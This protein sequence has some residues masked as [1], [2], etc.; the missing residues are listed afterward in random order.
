MRKL[1]SIA[2]TALVLTVGAFFVACGGD[3]PSAPAATLTVADISV[4]VGESSRIRPVFSDGRTA[5]VEYTFEGNDISI[6]NGEVEGLVADTV[7]EVTATAGELSAKFKVYVVTRPATDRGTLSFENVV[8]TTAQTITLAPVFSKEEGRSELTYSAVPAGILDFS[9]DGKM[10]VVDPSAIKTDT[11]VTVFAEGEYLSATFTVTVKAGDY[12]T[13]TIA[14][15]TVDAIGRV[16]IVPVFSKESGRSELTYECTP[17]GFLLFSEDG[18]ITVADPTAATDDMDVTVHA[19]GAYLET[20]FVVRVN[21]FDPGTLTLSLP[22]ERFE[23]R[24]NTLYANYSPR[25]LSLAFSSGWKT[26]EQFTYTVQEEFA[27]KVTVDAEGN[28]KAVGDFSVQ[29]TVRVTATSKS[30]TA[31]ADITVKYF[32]GASYNGYSLNLETQINNKL[33]DWR[34]RG[35]DKGGVLFVGDSFFDIWFWSN[36]YTT[37]RGKNA[38]TVGIGSST[39]TDWEI[40]SERLVYPFE[41]KA[42]VIHCGTNNIFDDRK[43]AEVGADDVKR[44]LTQIRTD[45][46]DTKIYYFSIEPRYNQDNSK[47]KPCNA[48]IKSFCD[49]DS[50]ITYIDSNSWCYTSSGAV[51]GSFFSDGTHPRLVNYSRYVEALTAAGLTYEPSAAHA[52]T[53]I[54]PI[55]TTTKDSV[56]NAVTIIYR[57]SGLVREFVL[58]GKLDITDAGN[59]A[60]IQFALDGI[61]N[62]FL[63]WDNQSTK[64]FGIGWAFQGVYENPGADRFV[65]TPG[66]TLTLYWKVAVTDKNAFFY[67]GT[68]ESGCTLRA[69]F[70]NGGLGGEINIGSENAATRV[71][72]MSAKTKEDDPADYAS[73]TS[74]SEFTFYLPSGDP[75]DGLYAVVPTP[76][77]SYAV[78][79]DS[80]PKYI[81]TADNSYLR[82]V[83]NNDANYNGATRDWA[84]VQNGSQAISGDFV[85]SYNFEIVNSAFNDITIGELPTTTFKNSFHGISVAESS[86]MNGWNNYHLF[87]SKGENQSLTGTWKLG[88][89][90]LTGDKGN[91][92][93]IK[94]KAM[95]VRSGNKVRSAFC[96][97]DA[98]GNELGWTA[99]SFDVTSA[100]LYVWLNAENIN[101]KLSGWNFSKD[102]ASVTAAMTVLGG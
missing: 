95:V 41:P 10:T 97:L 84:V 96:P 82:G 64:Q 38:Y 79:A 24:D 78:R 28:I 54:K 37:Y 102:A 45:L 11:V 76:G 2:I 60:H 69:V 34:N 65:F 89:G 59:N 21:S 53:T 42:V 7:T 6:A 4:T 66:S 3:D 19:T 91:L 52:V 81:S 14:D 88:G 99:L 27:D 57:G 77:S 83:G 46:P 86:N 35:G 87:Y 23:E 16:K 20:D 39:T 26:D 68:S 33:T 73:L 61:N 72:D 30:F 25:K 47:V 32:D 80:T 12:G 75:E 8:M 62:R 48:L 29:K 22:K 55:T 43:S 51:D 93:S 18:F 98:D 15:L 74:G 90:T 70:V 50:A 71:Y 5:E 58:S 13:L 9:V 56:G 92:S 63:I 101:G 36:F 1:L 40:L 49:A 17:A 85:L 44:L 31:S 67:L 94:T 100:N